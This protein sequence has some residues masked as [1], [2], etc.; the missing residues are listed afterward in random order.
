MFVVG[1]VNGQ[2][3]SITAFFDTLTYAVAIW[4]SQPNEFRLLAVLSAMSVFGAAC[5]FTGSEADSFR[6]LWAPSSPDGTDWTLPWGKSVH[7]YSPIPESPGESVRTKESSGSE[8]IVIP[9]LDT[10]SI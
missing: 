2:W 3:R 10:D 1:K 5:I 9:V 4:F 8:G 7:N 6:G